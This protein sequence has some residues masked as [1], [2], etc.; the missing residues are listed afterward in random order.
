MCIHQDYDTHYSIAHDNHVYWLAAL[1]SPLFSPT[2]MLL[3]PAASPRDL[4]DD[5]EVR[6][7]YRAPN[8]GA[9]LLVL[10][11]YNHDDLAAGTGTEGDYALLTLSSHLRMAEVVVGDDDDG[12][13]GDGGNQVGVR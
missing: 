1:S 13:G 10:L 6:N 7:A 12:G 9:S 4:R 11:A 5:H 3:Q 2:D 8:D